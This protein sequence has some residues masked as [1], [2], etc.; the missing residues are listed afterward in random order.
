MSS[1]QYFLPYHPDNLLK[2]SGL[3]RAN[4]LNIQKFYMLLAFRWVFCADL[5]TDR[6]L[7]GIRPSLTDWFLQPRWKVFTARYGLITL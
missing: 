1:S 6:S 3:L 5:R 4:K 2:P 7:N